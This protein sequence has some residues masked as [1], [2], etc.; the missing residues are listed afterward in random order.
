MHSFWFQ[1]LINK[2]GK[3]YANKQKKEFSD[4]NTFTN[5]LESSRLKITL[6]RRM[7]LRY[8]IAIRKDSLRK[9]FNNLETLHLLH[10]DQCVLV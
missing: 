4:T 3:K 6:L 2:K 5:T 1:L 8:T 9:W 7:I 10:P